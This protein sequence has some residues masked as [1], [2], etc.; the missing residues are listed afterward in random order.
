MSIAKNK[1]IAGYKKGDKIWTG[2]AF[3]N[4]LMVGTLASIHRET[5]SNYDIITEDIV[6]SGSSAILRGAM[7]AAALGPIGLLAGLSAKN[8]GVYTIAIEWRSGNRS[9]IEIDE[10]LYKI[11]LQSVF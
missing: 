8:K 1:V 10:T 4:S 5:V 6:K 9:L 2:G 11:F 7:G 3:K